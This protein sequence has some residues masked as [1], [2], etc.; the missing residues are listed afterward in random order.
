MSVASAISSDTVSL[1]RG[2]RYPKLSQFSATLQPPLPSFCQLT[3]YPKPMQFSVTLQPSQYYFRPHA[4]SRG[5]RMQVKWENQHICGMGQPRSVHDK[6]WQLTTLKGSLTL[7]NYT[8]LLPHHV[9]TPQ[10]NVL[11]YHVTLAYNET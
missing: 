6:K 3:R 11:S 7:A 4:F 2:Y 5:A 10:Y 9:A 1:V 8:K